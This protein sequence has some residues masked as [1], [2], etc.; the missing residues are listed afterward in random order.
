MIIEY[1][2]ES[3]LIAEHDLTSFAL[4]APHRYK[5]YEIAKR[6]SK[7]TRTIAHPSKELKFIQRSLVELFEK[8]LDIHKAAFAYKKGFGIK[9]NAKAHINSKYLLK[10]DFKNFFPSITPSLFFTVAEKKGVVFTAADRAILTGLV[11]WK[12]QGRDDLILSIGAPT[13]PIVS[14][15]VMNYFDEAVFDLCINRKITYTR[16]ADDI[17]FSTKLKDNLFDLPKIIETIL[18]ETVQGIEVNSEKTIFTSKA[19]NRHVTGVTL[20]ND[21]HISVGRD[22][23]RL[24]SAMIHQSKFKSLTPEDASHILGLISFAIHIEPEFLD[25]ILRKYG[26]EVLNNI[27]AKAGGI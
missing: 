25:R 23:K 9:D 4:T 3:L 11:F 8:S 27:K 5:V 10:M 2:S 21:N 6:N 1:L 13:S 24:I 16:Y 15:F 17:T 26:A 20:T 12:P 18:N 14:N 19:H 7:K 22:K